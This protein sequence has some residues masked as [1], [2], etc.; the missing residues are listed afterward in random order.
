MN[1]RTFG[2]TGL[3]LSEIG[4]G[5]WGI[6]KAMWVGAEDEASIKSLKA[7]RDAGVNFFDT[8]LTYGSG[9][10]ERIIQ[11]AF[12]NDDEVVIATKVPPKNMLW[13]AREGSKLRDVFPRDYVRACVDES[14][15]NLGRE[16]LDLEQFHVWMDDWAGEDEWLRS[17]EEMK[18][19]G[20]VRFIGI[21]INDHQPT[22][23]LRALRTGLIDSVQVIFNLFD[24]SPADELFPF[25]REHG[26]GVIARVPF[27]EGSLTGRIRPE[28]NFPEG[29]FRNT[30]FAGDRK[31][32]VWERVQRIAA[33]AGIPVENLP[34]LALRYCLS[35][36]AVTTV[37]PGMR[38]AKHVIANTAASDAGPL[39]PAT[40][41]KLKQHR[42]V[43]SFYA[44]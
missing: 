37:I 24:Q 29:D 13:P 15:R 43:R 23:S 35:D 3:R 39:S 11:R 38:S 8:A 1:Y 6:G 32:E 14:L 12:G 31:R 5:A 40:L 9:H 17:V 41:Q 26:I 42:W 20:K 28:T 33:D 7:A 30:Y 44:E 34:T 10:S 27:D 18:S 4:Y 21:S 36:P 19:S 22:N 2:R 16:Q 25:C